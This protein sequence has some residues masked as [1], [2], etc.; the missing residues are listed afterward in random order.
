MANPNLPIQYPKNVYVGAR[1]VPKFADPVE[2]S[3][4]ATYEPLTIVTYHGNSYTSRTFVPAGVIPTD[5]VYWAVT[6]NYNAQV[7]QYRQE[8]NQLEQNVENYYNQ[9][10][11][12]IDSV[13]GFSGLVKNMNII[14]IGDSY[15]IKRSGTNESYTDII[16]REWSSAHIEVRGEGSAGFAQAGE[17]GHTFWQLASQQGAIEPSKITH[18]IFLGGYNDGGKSGVMNAVS[19]ALNNAKQMYK[20]AKIMVGMVGGSVAGNSNTIANLY[21]TYINYKE[22]T[23]KAGCHFIDGLQY[24]LSWKDYFISDNF[25]PNQQGSNA[26]A[27]WTELG[28]LTGSV[29]PFRYVSLR[30]PGDYTGTINITQYGNKVTYKTFSGLSGPLPSGMNPN[31][32]IP[33]VQLENFCGINNYATTLG[34]VRFV[35]Q[36][37]KEIEQISYIT[38]YQAGLLSYGNTKI[39]FK[40]DNFQERTSFKTIAFTLQTEIYQ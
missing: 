13:Y 3:A 15:T 25:H 18:L 5:E 23:L 33:I 36:N 12:T 2:W 8:V 6:G 4:N 39:S 37:N 14:I 32:T 10:N 19:S 28:I 21:A 16:K 17:Q 26:L 38:I 40:P 24:V 7:E 30:N 34:D 22:A 1:Y 35:D 9:L 27:I 11:K 20:N 31:S 29:I